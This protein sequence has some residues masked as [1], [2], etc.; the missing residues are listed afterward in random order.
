LLSDKYVT[1]DNS[2]DAEGGTIQ[3]GDRT[4]HDSHLG[5]HA[6]PIWQ[7][8][9]LSS[10]AAMAKL[11]YTYYNKDPQKYVNHLLQLRLG[12]PTG[13]DLKG[14]R[15]P[16]V[17]NPGDKSWSK[18]TLPWMATGYEVMITPLHTCMLYNAVANNG[19]MM[20]PY[21]VSSVREYGKEIKKIK[22]TVLLEHIAEPSV[23]GQLQRCT[24][25]VVTDGTAKSIA[26]PFYAIS[27]KTGTAQV[28]D[29]GIAYTD[30]VYQGSFV[31]YFPSE[32]PKYTICVVIRTMPNSNEYYGGTIA[33]PVFRMVSDKIFANS[34]GSWEGQM[35]S[36]ARSGKNK[37]LVNKATEKS[38]KVLLA[39]IGKSEKVPPGR[40]NSVEQLT[41]DSMKRLTVQSQQVYHGIVPDVTGMG[42]KDAVYLL[43]NEGMQVQ[44]QGKGKVQV[45]SVPAGTRI[46]KGQNITLQL[47]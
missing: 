28:A 47:S 32:K 5:L 21:L 39:S 36:I 42:L 20:K 35:D 7:A 3:F 37:V 29:K 33:A 11:A 2:V 15:S 34:I 14:E 26:S 43:E 8:Y 27:G 25:A 40:A 23:I 44:I 9:A 10:N 6:M 12:L 17:K 1:V 31:G 13:I 22:P 30:G 24:R 46:I 45:Q 4:M 41:L 19:K 16:Y 18:T 38:Y